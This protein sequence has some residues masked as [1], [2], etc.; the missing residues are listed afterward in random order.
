MEKEIKLDRVMELFFRAMKGE[1]LSVQQ[2][3]FEYNVST[4]SITRDMNSLKGFLADHT[5]ILGYTELEYSSTNH[6]YS[7][8]MDNFLSNKF[9]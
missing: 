1:S 7:L 8:K 4:R 5:D 6:C 3:A 9:N 2:L